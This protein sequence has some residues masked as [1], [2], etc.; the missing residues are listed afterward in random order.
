MSWRGETEDGLGWGGLV[1]TA[2]ERAEERREAAR[3]A[4]ERAKDATIAQLLEALEECAEQLRHLAVALNAVPG[5]QIANCVAKA[6]AAISA[7]KV[8]A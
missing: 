1:P 3:V 4:K 6:N 8:E 7:A 2:A 5:S